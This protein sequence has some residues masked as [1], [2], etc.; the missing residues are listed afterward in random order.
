[1]ANCTKGRG[2]GKAPEKDMVKS[3]Q[4]RPKSRVFEG[5]YFG[6]NPPRRAIVQHDEANGSRRGGVSPPAFSGNVSR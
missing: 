5:F 3:G 2:E 1:M 4:N 6:E